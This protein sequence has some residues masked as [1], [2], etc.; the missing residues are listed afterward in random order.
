MRAGRSALGLQ[1]S[2]CNEALQWRHSIAQR[3]N[4]SQ[5]FRHRRRPVGCFGRASVTSAAL[6]VGSNHSQD[7]KHSF[8]FVL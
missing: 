8:S 4:R 1:I 3:V 6:A 2:N 7:A 5:P